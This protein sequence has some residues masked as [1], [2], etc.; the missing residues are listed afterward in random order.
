[1]ARRRILSLHHSRYHRAR[2]TS[3]PGGS[4]SAPRSSPPPED[5]RRG[6]ERASS[7]PLPVRSMLTYS[8]SSV[9]IPH[10]RLGGWTIK[11]RYGCCRLDR[12]DS[13]GHIALFGTAQRRQRLSWTPR[14]PCPELLSLRQASSSRCYTRHQAERGNA[15]TQLPEPVG[16]MQPESGYGVFATYIP[17]GEP[18]Y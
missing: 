11:L 18:P 3:L 4:A 15:L 7:P 16:T 9:A 8:V 10:R 1:L 17:I 12:F 6:T 14:L 2:S 5:H 13:C